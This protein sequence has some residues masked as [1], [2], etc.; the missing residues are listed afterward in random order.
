MNQRRR[1]S[2]KDIANKLGVST[3]LVSYVLND[4]FTDRIHPDTARKIKAVAEEL[5]Y[6]PNQIAKSLKNNKTFIIG[7]I[8]ADISNLFSSGIARVIEDEAKKYSYNVIF[9]SADEKLEKFDELI[10]IFVSRQ[11]DGIILA[12]TAGSVG[13]LQYLQ[14]R[15]VPF[16][17]IDRYFPEFNSV[18]SVVIDNYKASFDAVK[19]LA[20]NKF[21]YPA[22]ITLQSDLH[23]LKDRSRGFNDA[24]IEYFGNQKAN[25]IELQEHE[26]G[27]KLEE[28][29]LKLLYSEKPVDS[30]FFSTNKI[31]IEGLSVLA[32]RKIKVP[33][34]LGVVC[35]DEADA[36]NVFNTSISFV[37]QPLMQIGHQAVRL[38][39]DKINGIACHEN[40]VLN[41][42][43]NIGHSSLNISCPKI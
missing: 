36:Y 10:E 15:N 24:V 6:H 40:L 33:E 28:S 27:N 30:V 8:V 19:H 39:I 11:V 1:V 25:I 12:S 4:K 34:S 35:F 32:K 29:L 23:H 41:T 21:N 16:V 18:N 31:A 3:A 9:G 43:L 13:R 5:Q 42:Q 2:L 22:M 14:E 26:I 17:L 37:K 7:L 38:L 20:E